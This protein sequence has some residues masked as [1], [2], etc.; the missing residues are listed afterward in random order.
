MTT[1][2]TDFVIVPSISDTTTESVWSQTNILAVHAVA[3]VDERENVTVFAPG[4]RFRD[5]C[6]PHQYN[7]W[8][9]MS[10]IR[11]THQLL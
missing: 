9:S 11:S 5:S 8:S 6:C 10:I 1:N 2:E 4:L 3:L 7:S